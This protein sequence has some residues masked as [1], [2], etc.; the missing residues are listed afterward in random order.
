MSIKQMCSY[1]GCRVQSYL[2]HL[3]NRYCW[4]HYC[5]AQNKCPKERTKQGRHP[6]FCKE[7][8]CQWKNCNNRIEPRHQYCR[9]VHECQWPSDCMQPVLDTGTHCCVAHVCEYRNCPR[10]KIRRSVDG[11]MSMFVRCS[12]VIDRLCEMIKAGSGS[13][14]KIMLVWRGRFRFRRRWKRWCWWSSS[15]FLKWRSHKRVYLW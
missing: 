10:E 3:W 14:V 8:E 9:Q 15:W 11:V 4:N 5:L 12:N 13:I 2:H 6:I 7:H 1:N